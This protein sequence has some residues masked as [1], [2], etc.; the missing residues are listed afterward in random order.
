MRGCDNDGWPMAKIRG[1]AFEASREYC[2]C[3]NEIFIGRFMHSSVA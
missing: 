1:R 3:S 2:Q